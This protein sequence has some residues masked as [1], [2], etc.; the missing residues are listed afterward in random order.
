MFE[1]RDAQV[2]LFNKDSLNRQV[3]AL[4][5][6]SPVP[7]TVLQTYIFNVTRLIIGYVSTVLTIPTPP[8]R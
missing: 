7:D 1:L 8:S 5:L 4:F 3:Q 2:P 6:I